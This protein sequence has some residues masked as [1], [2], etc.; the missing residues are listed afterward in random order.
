MLRKKVEGLTTQEKLKIIVRALDAKL[1]EEIE[2][3]EITDLTVLAE[4]F[5]IC[6]GTSST[7]VKALADEVEYQMGEAGIQPHHVEGKATNWILL[8]YT[9]IVVHVFNQEARTFYSLDRLWSD[10]K[11]ID[12]TPFLKEKEEG[13]R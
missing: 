11:K 8:D 12:I 1:G 3:I 5:V 9:G 6:S 13:S 7:Q 2:V 10:G 4:Y